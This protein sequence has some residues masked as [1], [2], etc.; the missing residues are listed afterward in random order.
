MRLLL[1]PYINALSQ[2]SQNIKT[3]PQ[4]KTAKKP[5]KKLTP[6]E[7]LI[8]AFEKHRQTTQT[9]L[10]DYIADGGLMMEIDTA[11][12]SFRDIL[13]DWEAE[14][15]FD[16]LLDKLKELSGSEIR[17]KDLLEICDEDEVEEWVKENYDS[18]RITIELSNMNDRM[19]L[20][21]FLKTVIYPNFNDQQSFIVGL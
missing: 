5:E 6:L 3:M 16:E 18:D 2:I 17:T 9:I 10:K 8:E 1:L 20:E 7:I 4:T 13:E 19:K 11:E 21:N 14:E 12:A 15:D